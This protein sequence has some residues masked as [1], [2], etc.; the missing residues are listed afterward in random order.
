MRIGK[1]IQSIIITALFV[2]V[3]CS[4][5]PNISPW[6][7]NIQILGEGSVTTSYAAHESIHIDGNEQFLALAVIESWPGNGSADNPIIISGYSFAAAEHML[8][9]NNS[10]LHFE[11][12]DNQL[13][14]LSYEWC[15]VAILN[16]ANGVIRDNYVRRAAAGIHV[17]AV[18][19]MTIEGNEVHDSGF[20][21]IVVEDGSVNVLVKDNIVYDNRDYGIHVGNPYGSATSNDIT[22]AGNIVYN[23][24]PSGLVL[25]EA[26]NCIIEY[27][28]IYSNEANGIEVKSG[29][30]YIKY[31]N[32]TDSS[33]GIFIY[34]GNATVS[35]NDITHSDYGICIA[36]EDN[37]ISNNN[38][39]YNNMDGI[40]LYHSYA[41]GL[42]GSNNLITRNV[43][44]NNSRWGLN[45]AWSTDKNVVR[46]NYFF[47]NGD[48][49]QATD[50]G[51]DNIIDGNY[52]NDW[53]SPDANNNCIVDVPYTI[54]GNAENSDPHPMVAPDVEIYPWA[55]PP[56]TCES[57]TTITTT[58]HETPTGTSA[59]SITL[60]IEVDILLIGITVSA[61]VIIVIFI[62]KR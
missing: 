61:L 30:H 22:I 12:V 10:N 34:E 29:S 38:L 18:E 24:Q 19:N 6:R 39:L 8:R 7:E 50:D 51:T 2:L 46:N 42:S 15:G 16:S 23:N 21:G 58:T 3:F 52:W 47:E 1:T 9:I 14:G 36:T 4:S 11:F 32:I 41:T 33:F 5:V 27:N 17:V 37:T 35:H 59:E 57:E 31:N 56:C 13:D 25:L 54:D 26:N 40:R 62:K 48:I 55:I 49:C 60:P 43:F 44:A 45:F 28:E 53:T 20:S